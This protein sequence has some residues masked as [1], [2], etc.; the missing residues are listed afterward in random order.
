M[1]RISCMDCRQC[2]RKGKPSVMRGSI[3]CDKHFVHRVQT[4]K[5]T[6]LFAGI[7]DRFM[8]KRY[9]PE[10]GIKKKG[11]RESWFYE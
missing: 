9:D 11:F 7:R 10:R 8:E 2:N 6:G 1:N 5:K 4:K 3:Y